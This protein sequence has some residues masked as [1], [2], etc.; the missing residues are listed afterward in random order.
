MMK[1]NLKMMRKMKKMKNQNSNLS[2]MINPAKNNPNQNENRNSV[3]YIAY[4]PLGNPTKLGSPNH[5]SVLDFS[6]DSS[7]FDPSG[8]VAMANHHYEK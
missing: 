6:S 5:P 2:L 7:A 4:M 3:A 1:K 8:L